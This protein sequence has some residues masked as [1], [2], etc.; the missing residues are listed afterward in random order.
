MD[1]GFV[2][3]APGEGRKLGGEQKANME[4]KPLAARVRVG[5][6]GW[7]Y[8]DWE[9]IVYPRQK[10]RGFHAASYLARFFDTI[11]INSTFYSPPT[12]ATAASW[13]RRIEHNKDFLFTAKLWQRFTHERTATLED[14][15][16]FKRA[17]QPLADAGRLGALLLQFPWSFKN[18]R[19]ERDYLAGL[20]I[21]FMEYP[22]VVEVRH[23]S[24]NRPETFQMLAELGVGFSNIDQPVIG[25]SLAPSEYVIPESHLGYVRLHGR[26]YVKWFTSNEN[27][28]ERYNY[29]YSV[30]ELRP[31]A[32]RIGNVSARTDVTFVITNNHFQGKGVANALQLL[33][34]LTH[35][36]VRAPEDL[37][38][39]FPELEKIVEVSTSA[40]EPLQTDLAFQ[41][42]SERTK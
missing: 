23:R 40:E 27:S 10:P 2:L 13:V 21:R 18:T 39:R 19:E 37:L 4:R 31:W 26:N 30:E 42:A 28:S 20:C 9:G 22:R 16:T 36:R 17:L 15:M 33:N 29:L 25:D 1:E 5:P 12:A 7:S 32:E 35:R 8:P 14:E 6:A 41:S 38:R 11:E 3:T 34:L 24:W